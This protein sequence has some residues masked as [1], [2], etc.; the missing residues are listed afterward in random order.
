MRSASCIALSLF[1]V[2]LI[3]C[4]GSPKKDDKL[5]HEQVCPGSNPGHKVVVITYV[6]PAAHANAMPQVDKGNLMVEQGD[7]IKFILNGP[8]KNIVVSTTGKDP[9]KEGWLNG[10]G[11]KSP[12]NPG[13]DRFFVCVPKNFVDWEE[14]DLCDANGGSDGPRCEEFRYNVDATGH[15]TLDPIVTV[16][17]F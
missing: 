3:G 16:Q 14:A 5:V 13:S 8:D 17:E 2:F 11:V 4:E 7:K 9:E 6:D 1:V 15:E 12:N 10:G